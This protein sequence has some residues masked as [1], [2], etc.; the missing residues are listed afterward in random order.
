MVPVSKDER[1]WGLFGHISA[2]AGTLVP[3]GNIIAPLIIWQTK[4]N[5]LPFASREAKESLNFQ[6]SLTIYTL[7]A[8]L[9]MFVLIGFI[10][11]P[12][13][14]LAGIIFTII[15]GLKANNGVAYRY[16]LTLRLI[17]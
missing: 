6:I 1:T 10:L 14:I 11:T 7:V 2:F 9:S 16:P 3:F 12:L 4:K 17:D 13:I 8:G 15:G 5:E